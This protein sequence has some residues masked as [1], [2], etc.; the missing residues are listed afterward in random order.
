MPGT[1]SPWFRIVVR[2]REH[3]RHLAGERGH[4]GERLV[5][6]HTRMSAVRSDSAKGAATHRWVV[7]ASLSLHAVAVAPIGLYGHSLT[8][9]AVGSGAA[10]HLAQEMPGPAADT[11]ELL[12][13]QVQSLRAEVDALRASSDAALVRYSALDSAVAQ[14][15][16]V[17]ADE[18]IALR[19]SRGR[20]LL[21]TAAGVL[22]IGLVFV[23]WSGR[24]SAAGTQLEEVRREL[25]TEVESKGRR[26]LEE[27]ASSMEGISQMLGRISAAGGD[28]EPDHDLVLGIC[29]EVN[30]IEKNLASMD[31]SARGHRQLT[32]CVRRVKENLR[33]HRYEI[34]ELL[35]REYDGGMHVEVDFVEDEQLADGQRVITR[36]DKPEV[37][38]LGKIIQS[39]SVRVSVGL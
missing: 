31:S 1:G 39:A 17:L 14:E 28:G 6:L 10:L 23:W 5:G 36:I 24:R 26:L 34:T 20:L 2:P 15:R 33:S 25:G 27:Q 4:G 22:L 18:L 21:V 16:R 37:R 11:L 38:H 9:L 8:E 30:R 3:S 12:L 35:G 7:A 32:S 13:E 29:N 19:Q